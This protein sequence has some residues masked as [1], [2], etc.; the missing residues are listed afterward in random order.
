MD[1]IR[2]LMERRQQLRS[3]IAVRGVREYDD[4]RRKA[5]EVLRDVIEDELITRISLA[6]MRAEV[7]VRQKSRSMRYEPVADVLTMLPCGP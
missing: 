3:Q 2:E 1:E 7:R 4:V 6:E 5:D